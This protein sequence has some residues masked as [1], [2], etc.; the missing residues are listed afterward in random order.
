MLLR[1]PHPIWAAAWGKEP[2]LGTRS[3][4]SPPGGAGPPHGLPREVGTAKGGEG[5]RRRESGDP[6]RAEPTARER[7]G[8]ALGT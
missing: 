3:P 8:E 1:A 6:Y 5:S 7:K 4:S 2:S